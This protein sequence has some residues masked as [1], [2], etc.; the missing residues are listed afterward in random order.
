M[1]EVS[2][3]RDRGER[4]GG[5]LAFRPDVTRI[6]ACTDPSRRAPRRAAS[7][8]RFSWRRRWP[9][10]ASRA[11]SGC[12]RRAPAAPPAHPA[13]DAS[14]P[15]RTRADATRRT[16]RSASAREPLSARRRRTARRRR[17]ADRTRRALR[18]AVLRLFAVRARKRVPRLRRRVRRHRSP[19]LLRDEGELEPRG[20][21]PP[22]AAG[23]RL[24]HR[25]G[26][27]TRARDRGRRRSR[28]GRLLRRRQDR[29]RDGG[30]RLPPGF[31]ASTSSRP[32]S[33]T[34]STRSPAASA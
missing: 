5:V 30:W 22:G 7:P 9:A 32:P 2:S 12:R 23:L 13:A 28:Q 25:F 24:R 15:P 31:S 17:R 14:A 29:G 8:P 21:E 10:A 19:R 1:I 20:A 6:S 11:R 16:T 18:H 4:R 34:R 27:R 3:T 26:R 33:S